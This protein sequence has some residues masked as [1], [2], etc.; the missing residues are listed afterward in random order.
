[1]KATILDA[2]TLVVV[3]LLV[4]FVMIAVS[5]AAHVMGF[6]IMETDTLGWAHDAFVALLALLGNTAIASMN[7]KTSTPP[8]STPT[9]AA[10][11]PTETPPPDTQMKP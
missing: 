2:G 10:D 3:L 8:P 6:P 5:F 4:L 1:M 9:T 7:S 11:K